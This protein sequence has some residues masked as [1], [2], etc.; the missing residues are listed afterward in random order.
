MITSEQFETIPVI[1]KA[2]KIGLGGAGSES[3]ADPKRRSGDKPTDTY[4]VDTHLAPL[5]G[6]AAKHVVFSP[7]HNL[8]GEPDDAISAMIAY[9]EQFPEAYRIWSR[10]S[11][12][13]KNRENL[14][15]G[16][17]TVRAIGQLFYRLRRK[18]FQRFCGKLIDR[19]AKNHGHRN[20]KTILSVSLGGG[21]GS[22]ICFEAARDIKEATKIAPT[23]VGLIP[24]A[25]AGRNNPV[26]ADNILANVYGS[27]VDAGKAR[28][29][30]YIDY[31]VVVGAD[32]T[33]GV[34]L[35]GI[36]DS[37]E[38]LGDIVDSLAQSWTR[39]F[40]AMD[41]DSKRK[42]YQGVPGTI[43]T[44]FDWSDQ[45]PEYVTD[46]ARENLPESQADDITRNI[47]D[48]PEAYVD[49]VEEL[50]RRKPH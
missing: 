24:K 35:D 31:L 8:N 50:R 41:V 46:V 29:A 30:G 12:E 38:A 13:L 43:P 45:V 2:V 32:N 23:I 15:S 6:L 4:A 49:D 3:I 5:T 22:G 11:P 47:A 40:K 34:M 42:L 37:V 44:L 18:E 36:D 33:Q 19:H 48:D 1:E 26:D 20:P 28:R 16:A 10:L 25:H 9:P 39:G 21:S 27:I 7:T 14:T 17:G